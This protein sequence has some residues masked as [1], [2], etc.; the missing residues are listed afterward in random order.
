LETSISEAL[1]SHQGVDEVAE[2]GERGDE[3]EQFSQ[4][5]AWLRS[6][7][8][9]EGQPDEAQRGQRQDDGDDDEV[10][11]ASRSD[12]CRSASTL[13][14]GHKD[15]VKEA[16]RYAKNSSRRKPAPPGGIC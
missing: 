4:S 12:S 2:Q 14:P 11:P 1:R 13:T 10:H 7:L 16:R 3:G 8:L 15:G 6:G 5:M 9:D